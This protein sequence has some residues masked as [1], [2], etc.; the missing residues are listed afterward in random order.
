[1]HH[2][3][4]LTD[5]INP[6][7]RIGD[8]VMQPLA[9]GLAEPRLGAGG[10]ILEGQRLLIVADEMI[11]PNEAVGHFLGFVDS[12]PL[13]SNNQGMGAGKLHQAQAGRIDH[14]GT[15]PGFQGLLALQ[16]VAGLPQGPLNGRRETRQIIFSTCRSP[17]VNASMAT[18][19]P[20]A[21]ETKIKGISEQ[22]S[23]ASRSADMP[24][25][26]GNR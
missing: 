8:G 17:R 20:M 11:E 26:T 3:L 13:I 1:M 18:S 10:P 25:Y 7:A 5:A 16:S 24:S 23:C 6:D 15:L 4:A 22:R 21:P 19:S 9:P 14:V 2:R 12:I